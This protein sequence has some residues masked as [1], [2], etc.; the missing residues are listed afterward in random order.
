MGRLIEKPPDGIGGPRWVATLSDKTMVV[1]RPSWLGNSGNVA[2]PNDDP[3]PMS[4]WRRLQ[5]KCL[6]D[7]LRIE[8]LSLWT[9]W[10]SLDAPDHQGGYGYF[11]LHKS[12]LNGH[13]RHRGCIGI[14]ICWWNGKTVSVVKV[15]ADGERIL[16]LRT[17]W[18]PCMIGAPESQPA[19]KD[20]GRQKQ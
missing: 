5:V 8:K 10:G 15:M 17:K 20:D 19:L 18:L 11:E 7:S 13:Q 2:L 3:D 14:A 16:E 9:Q 12:Q 1:G 4:D 6:V